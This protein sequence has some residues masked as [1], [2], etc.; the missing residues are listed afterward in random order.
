MSEERITWAEFKAKVEE[1]GVKDDSLV[2][3]IDMHGEYF[4]VA[5]VHEDGSFW[6]EDGIRKIPWDT[7]GEE[8]EPGTEFGGR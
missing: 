4:P 2:S 5:T 6:V 7:E 8:I 1:Q 3:Y